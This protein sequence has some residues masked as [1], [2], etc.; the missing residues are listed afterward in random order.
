[1]LLP[2]ILA[3]VRASIQATS[4]LAAPSKH[5]LRAVNGTTTVTPLSFVR[6]ASHQS[7]GRANGAKQGPGKRLGA[8]KSGGSSN[9]HPNP[10]HVQFALHT[11]PN[12]PLHY[13]TIANSLTNRR[14][15]HPGQHHLPPTRHLVVPRRK[16]Q[17]RARPLRLRNGLG[18]RPVL[19]RSTQAPEETV[20][21]RRARERPTTTIP[22][23]HGAPQE[24]GHGCR[25]GAAGRST[26]SRGG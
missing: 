9:P 13:D 1:M 25:N 5:A 22:R 19:Q 23:E 2:R 3:P 11:A 10:S 16:L 17:I 18:I 12:S 15:R 20:H 14:I 21:W 8:K 4:K 24:I 7:Q 26:R 6:H